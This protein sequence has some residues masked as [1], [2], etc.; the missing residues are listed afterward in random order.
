MQIQTAVILA[1]LL[2]GLLRHAMEMLNMKGRW[3]AD[4]RIVG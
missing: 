3:F 4:R 2:E 1:Y